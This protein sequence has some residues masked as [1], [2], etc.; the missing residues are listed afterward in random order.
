MCSKPVFCEFITCFH[1]ILTLHCK[2]DGWL[3]PAMLTQL[4]T[5]ELYNTGEWLLLTETVSI[6]S[7]LNASRLNSTPEF[8]FLQNCTIY[9]SHL[10]YTLTLNKLTNC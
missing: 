6:V 2:E 3:V 10:P 7:D 4:N 9:S 5:R 1:L 8:S